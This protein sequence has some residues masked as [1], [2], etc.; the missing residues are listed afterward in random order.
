M[1]STLVLGGIYTPS[2]AGLE[3][4]PKMSVHS[5]GVLLED[6]VATIT[7]SIYYQL[8]PFLDKKGLITVTHAP[9]VKSQLS[10]TN[11]VQ[12]SP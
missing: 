7:R 5:L 3:L 4:A 9:L 6:Q 11:S 10:I 2:L 8:L 1:G 12:G